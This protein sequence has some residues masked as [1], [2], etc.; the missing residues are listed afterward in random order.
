MTRF[1]RIRKAR[2]HWACSVSLLTILSIFSIICRTLLGKNARNIHFAFAPLALATA[3]TRVLG[4]FVTLAFQEF[5]CT[6][7][8]MAL[9]LE[10]LLVLDAS[11]VLLRLPG[12]KH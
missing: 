3:G 7:R 10:G 12:W 8:L 1:R 4:G 2:T 11:S 9:L 6:T 5:R